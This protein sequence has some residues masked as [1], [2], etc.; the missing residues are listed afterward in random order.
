MASILLFRGAGDLATGAAIRLLRC[1]LRLVLTELPQPMAVRRTVSFAEAVYSGT[2]T[3]EGFTARRVDDPGDTLSILAILGQGQV[4]VLVDPLC[5]S[6]GQLHPAVIVDARMVKLPPEP[7]GYSPSLYIGL[8]P[9]FSAGINCQAAIETRRGFALGRLYWQGSPQADTAQPEGDSA[10]V[11]RAPRAGTLTSLAAIGEHVS[12]GQVIAVV[13]SE[14]VS[15]P[16]AG[17]LRG[18][19]HPSVQLERGMKIGDIDPRDDPA[20]CRL[21]SDKALAIGGA[22]LEACLARPEVRSVLWV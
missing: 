20:L 8:G 13:S 1:G 9:G 4:P 16:F 17:T 12:A 21:V 14:P 7:I 2:M 3:V 19:I 11:L 15:A 10:R 18:L 6:A 5:Q 22:V